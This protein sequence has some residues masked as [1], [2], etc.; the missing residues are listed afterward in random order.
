MRFERLDVEV[1]HRAI[2]RH[3]ILHAHDELHVERRDE[4]APLRHLRSAKDMTEIEGL[5]LRLHPVGQ[6]LPSEPVDQLRAVLVDA[7]GE[8]VRS[9]SERSHVGAKRQ[10]APALAPGSRSATSG[11]LNN[12]ARA[13]LAQPFQQATEPLR[14]RAGRFIVVAHMGVHNGGSGLHSRLG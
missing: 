2:D 10:H 8:I 4:L 7:G 12:Q 3:R 13:I 9:H 1:E 14:V 6:H 5:D 11:E